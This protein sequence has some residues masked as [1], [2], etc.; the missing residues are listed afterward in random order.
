MGWSLDLIIDE[1]DA[2]FGKNIHRVSMPE[3]VRPYARIEYSREIPLRKKQLLADL[4]PPDVYIM[5]HPNTI[6]EEPEEK[7]APEFPKGVELE[8]HEGVLPVVAIVKPGEPSG[9]IHFPGV[10]EV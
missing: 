9:K 7:P 2:I 3:A 6:W 5:F 4:F 8:R 1:I 10:S